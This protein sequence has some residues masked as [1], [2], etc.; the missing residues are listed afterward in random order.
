MQCPNCR[1]ENQEESA[2]CLRCGI[3][4]A[5]YHARP[6]HVVAATPAAGGNPELQNELRPGLQCRLLAIPV[7]LIVARIGVSLFPFLTGFLRMLVHE[8]GHAVTAWLCGYSATP[9]LWFTSISESP[10]LWMTLLIVGILAGASFWAWKT[11]RLY[12]V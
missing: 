3:V 11:S 6:Q 2:E 5:K 8:C 7:A 4:F 10:D 12:L 9:G 1:F